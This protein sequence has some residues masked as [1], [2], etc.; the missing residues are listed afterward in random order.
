[1]ES[2]NVS[3]LVL[4]NG[5]QI[6]CDLKEVYDGEGESKK[7]ICLMMIHPYVLSLVT[8]DNQ[9]DLQVKFGKWCPYSPDTR[10]KIPYD[11][12]M[13][14]GRCDSN[15]ELAYLNRVEEVETTNQ[16]T[17]QTTDE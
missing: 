12:V 1:M 11:C 3:I 2:T 6:V 9:E 5:D 15:L 17:A 14:I 10:F 16:T 8:T 7:G 13:S 4:K